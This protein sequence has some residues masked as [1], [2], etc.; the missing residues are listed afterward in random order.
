MKKT[1][2]NAIVSGLAAAG[3]LFLAHPAEAQV[4]VAAKYF[5][6]NT[7]FVITNN[8]AT[9]LSGITIKGTGY[10]GNSVSG[11]VHI[12][13]LAA[14]ASYVFD[15]D[16]SSSAF[17]EDFDDDHFGQAAYT[18]RGTVDGRL[19]SL[20][21]SPHNNTTG[22]FIPFL[23]N[24]KLGFEYDVEFQAIDVSPKIIFPHSTLQGGG[25]VP[26]SLFNLGTVNPG[27]ND[28]LI[29]HGDF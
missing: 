1:N 23:G 16:G 21:F 3:A 29:V 13:T 26:G 15:F 12:P 6:D 19:I 17:T 11:T 18:L 5:D 27:H 24:D 9:P 22:G 4:S 8:F 7:S 25:V 20:S 10:G 28:P 14:G 2:R